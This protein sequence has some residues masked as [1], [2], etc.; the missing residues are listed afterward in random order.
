MGK[1]NSKKSLVIVESPAKAKTINRYLG[2]GYVVKATMGHVRDL[3]QKRFGVKING[4]F[5]PEY[6]VLPSRRK[7]VEELKK[8][9]A[10]AGAIYLATDLDREG[11]AIAWHLC[12]A[13][14]VDESAALRVIF[15]EITRE[16]IRRAFENPTKIDLN[17]VNAQQ[18][19][20]I[21]DRIVGYMLSPLLWKKV[22]KGLSAGR[23]QSVAVR[24]IVEREREI[25]DFVPQEYWTITALLTPE[26]EGE[27]RTVFEASVEKKDG[28]KLEL[29]NKD[30]A[31]RAVE[32]LRGQEFVVAEYERKRK[33]VSPPPP[34]ITSTLQ[35]QA[36]IRLRFR[37][38]RTMMIAQQLYEGV[39][40]GPYGT[41]ALIT[42]MRTD[43]VRCSEQSIA[44]CREKIKGR[45]GEEFLLEKPRRFKAGRRAQ[46]AHE[47]IRPT[48][49][50][51]E[52]EEVAKY[53]KPEQAKLYKLIYERFLAS[54]M[55]PA[56]FSVTTATIK[57]GVYELSAKGQELVSAGFTVLTPLAEKENP[58]LPA[59]EQEQTLRLVEL[60]PEQ[61]F[62]K[63]PPRYTE[64]SLVKTLE[65]KGIGR[66]STYAPIITTIQ[67]RGYVKLIKRQFHATELG[68]LVTDKLVQY[69][70]DII[71]VQ[72]TSKLEEELDKIEEEHIDWQQVLREF[73]ERF[74]RDLNKAKE[75]MSTEKDEETGLTCEKCGKPLVIRWSRLGR[76]LGC[77]GYPECDYTRSLDDKGEKK[78]PEESPYTCPLCGKPLLYREG[79]RGKFLGCSGF[80]ECRFTAAIDAKAR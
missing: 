78:P 40:L 33:T 26:L 27:P 20:R 13:L 16:A 46:E 54:Q 67:Q 8:S 15:N 71:N 29:N 37:A 34:F 45:F 43:S 4:G 7:I 42:Y 53:L 62:T 17:K 38:R 1:N 68:M 11:E 60:K 79:R 6:R 41:V 10:E 36:S 56:V 18:A 31:E 23:V 75:E 58:P 2:S 48:D 39:D 70:P 73:Y 30:E 64:A 3:P 77:S 14:G 5:V 9:A 21:L 80:P 74:I 65:A 47:A 51:L 12:K 52:P 55:A 66:P 61:H 24:L 32:E 19:R 63:P 25:R 49:L 44:A 28:K 50:N 72:F 59:L 57:A 35:Q 69:F 76:F 22:T